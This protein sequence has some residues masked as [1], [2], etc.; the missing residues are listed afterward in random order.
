MSAEKSDRLLPLVGRC[1][2]EWAEKKLP[3]VVV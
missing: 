2:E 1:A 3:E